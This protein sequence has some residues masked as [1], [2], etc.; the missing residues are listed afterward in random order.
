MQRLQSYMYKGTDSKII[1]TLLNLFIGQHLKEDPA[2]V[3]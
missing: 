1:V 3:Q 2:M